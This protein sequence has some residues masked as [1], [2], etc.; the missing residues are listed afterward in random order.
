MGG[1][2]G[3]GPLIKAAKK[4][5]KDN[6]DVYLYIV[7][8]KEIVSKHLDIENLDFNGEFVSASTHLDSNDSHLAFFRKKDNSMQVAVN[9]VKA[10]TVD[11]VISAGNSGAYVGGA[12]LVLKTM[13]NV[14][15]PVFMPIIPTITNQPFCLLDGGAF[16]EVNSEILRQWSVL[17][18]VF[19]TLVLNKPS[20]KV[21]LLNIGTEPGKGTKKYIEYHDYLINK[22]ENFVGNVEARTVLDGEID[23]ILCDGFTGNILLKAVEGT[24]K[25]ISS[26]LKR[27]LLKSPLGI[28]AALLSFNIF[29]K[30]RKKLDYREVG[31]ALVL[32][33]NGVVVK[34]HGSTDSTAMINALKL[35]HKTVKFETLKKIQTALQ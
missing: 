14:I 10:K 18:S 5:S 6:K 19:S 7:G 23:V 24:A 21:G 34:A 30:I 13:K 26:I 12:T 2:L 4:F 8:N 17:G 35:A 3:P 16:L 32:G 29:R 33:L 20:P 31:G 9:L 22:V 15:R 1:D 11:A 27:S 25:S 28:T